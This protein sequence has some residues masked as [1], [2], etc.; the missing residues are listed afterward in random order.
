MVMQSQLRGWSLDIV[1]CLV[2]WPTCMNWETCSDAKPFITGP[3][4]YNT[5]LFIHW[6]HLLTNTFVPFL[7]TL[8]AEGSVAL[9]TFDS[10]VCSCCCISC[11]SSIIVI[12][13]H[14]VQC[15]PPSSRSGCFIIPHILID[16]DDVWVF[17]IISLHH[18]LEPDLG[19]GWQNHPN[20]TDFD[21]W[22]SGIQARW[23]SHY[24]LHFATL[25]DVVSSSPHFCQISFIMICLVHCSW[26]LIPRMILMHLWWKVSS[27]LVCPLS[28]VQ[29]S[30]PY[31]STERTH[32][33]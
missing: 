13:T 3:T 11:L 27:F 22:W 21:I 16:F 19:H 7:I 12:Q 15:P 25:I 14:P 32:A 18:F 8:S 31:N 1:Q 9:L 23:S 29:N 10:Q 30:V 5:P 17:S 2:S 26:L 6:L 20:S 4:L 28:R 24:S 33:R